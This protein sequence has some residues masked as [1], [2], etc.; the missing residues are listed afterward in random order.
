[1]PRPRRTRE[2][3]ITRQT[4]AD[5]QRLVD[6]Q[7]DKGSEYV[8][9]A[10]DAYMRRNPHADVATV[11]KWLFELM[12]AALPSFTELS[13][14][15]SC[16]FMSELADAYGWED[17]KPEIV[18]STDY[19][20]V[21][22]RLHYLAR[23]LA[24][25]DVQRFKDEVADVTRYFVRRA[26]Q[27]SMIENCGKAN[28]RYARV[29]SGLET[30]SFCFMLASRGFVYVSEESAGKRHQFHNHCTCTIVPGAEGRTKID[31][32]DPE[33]M[34]RNWL[35]CANTAGVQTYNRKTPWTDDERRAVMREV[36]TRD[37]HWLYTGDAP[38]LTYES[39][40]LRRSKE[41][42][43]PHEIGTANHMRQFGI[44]TNFVEDEIPE[45]DKD[46]RKTG[47]VIGYADLG[48]GFELKT[49]K[50]ASSYNT[51]N[52]Y[53]K[54]TSKKRNARCVVFDNRGNDS[55]PDGQLVEWLNQSRTFRRGRVYIIDHEGSYRFIR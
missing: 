41:E 53:L 6:A 36:E 31:G 52:G 12:Q 14:T 22:R 2:T 35:S 45:V 21:D 50:T 48:S 39:A 54:N 11:R 28:V 13:E 47:R 25:G 7:A 30:C 40:A 4:I 34:Y 17:V 18:G 20:L 24:D 27:D 42:K 5:Y 33:T 10:L 16:E 37:W 44:T 49:T 19:Q 3:R 15:L 46:G 1:M 23:Y 51:I 26:A 38:K 43:Y 8:R 32:Y 29:P 9:R 55:M